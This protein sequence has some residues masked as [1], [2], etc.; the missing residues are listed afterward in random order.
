VLN[1]LAE[2]SL[3]EKQYDV[4]LKYYKKITELAPKK[5]AAYAGIGY[6]Y[7]LK[8]DVDKEIDYYKLA[9]RYDPE[10]DASFLH[11]G[12][13]YESK[14]MFADAYRSYVKAYEL[15][16]EATKARTKIPQMRIRM[17]EKKYKE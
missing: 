3:K 4:A 5:A 2:Y 10:D 9:V 1:I 8:G 7:A 12:A 6:V 14:E 17:L 11:L 13:A 16:P 15:N